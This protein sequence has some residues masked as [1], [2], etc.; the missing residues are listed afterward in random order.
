VRLIIKK[1]TIRSL[2]LVET[3]IKILILED[4]GIESLKLSK[5]LTSLK[6]NEMFFKENID[7]TQARKLDY[8]QISQC[9]FSTIDL[10]QNTSL[11]VLILEFNEFQELDLSQ[12]NNLINLHL[13]NNQ[14]KFL[15][16]QNSTSL[17]F[18]D[19]RNNSKYLT[20]IVPE[21]YLNAHG[22][23]LN[24]DGVKF[25]YDSNITLIKAQQKKYIPTTQFLKNI[26]KTSTIIENQDSNIVLFG[27]L[28][29]QN[30][31]NLQ[32]LN[33]TNHLIRKVDFSSNNKLTS[34]T[35][36]NNLINEIILPNSLSQ[37]KFLNLSSNN[38]EHLNINNF[39]NLQTVDLSKNPLR[40][41]RIKNV[42]K[43][44]YLN[45]QNN[46]DLSFVELRNNS[47]YLTVI[48]PKK[49][50]NVHGEFL[51]TDSVKFQYDSSITLIKAQQKKYIS[52][53]QFLKNIKKT[54]IS[55]RNQD[56]NIVLFGNL[57]LQNFPNLQELNLTNH[58]IR[59]VDLSSN[60]KLVSVTLFNNLI[61]EITLP[62][63]LSQLRHLNLSSNNLE[64]LNINNFSNLQTV[65]LSK[66]PLR[67]LTIKNTPELE[68]L[69]LNFNYDITSV[70]FKDTYS[71]IKNIFIKETDKL[72]KLD[73]SMLSDL[74]KIEIE[75]ERRD[76]DTITVYS[77]DKNQENKLFPNLR[78]PLSV[79]SIIHKRQSTAFG[80]PLIFNVFDFNANNQISFSEL[81]LND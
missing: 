68:Y 74:T 32:E 29:L 28:R 81:N 10:S 80:Q 65:D 73:V 56:S 58:L 79:I 9:K 13:K 54:S 1:C 2:D 31:L 33:L 24:T 60:N 61:N 6:I 12:N 69:N 19:L 21:K 75:D 53:N 18:V 48:V 52:I 30:F 5:E 26:K 45:L 57:Q 44:E 22:E 78:F 46:P 49:Y 67:D 40:D 4:S 35:L 72:K 37:L 7:F 63:S 11:V 8:L 17:D 50:L 25:Q 64:H 59:K 27:D 39:S 3:G 66:N 55:I 43:L 36:F 70:K 20:A 77:R 34:V 15:N 14:L 38:L 51:N 42:P 23:F 62:Y 76:G 47:K 16:L 41:L 71:K